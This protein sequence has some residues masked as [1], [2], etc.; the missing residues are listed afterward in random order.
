MRGTEGKIEF[1]FF[2]NETP[3]CDRIVVCRGGV[4]CAGVGLA[5]GGLGVCVAVV[6]S[7]V[8][9]GCGCGCGCGCGSRG[10][11]GVRMCACGRYQKQQQAGDSPKPVG[12]GRQGQE[13]QVDSL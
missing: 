8:F 11:I 7:V 5:Q 12:E 10:L 13:G 4:C 6:V 9:V 2:R 3:Y 1:F